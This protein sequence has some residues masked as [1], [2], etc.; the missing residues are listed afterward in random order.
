MEVL[1]NLYSVVAFDEEKK[2]GYTHR[3]PP[4]HQSI[5]VHFHISVLQIVY[6]KMPFS[7]YTCLYVQKGAMGG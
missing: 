2:G 6:F 7:P 5:T 1:K 3:Y 4:R